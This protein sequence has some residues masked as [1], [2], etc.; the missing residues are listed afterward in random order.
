MNDLLTQ[1]LG[2]DEWATEF[3]E[4][5]LELARKIKEEILND[6][7]ISEEYKEKVRNGE[8]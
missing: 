5:A 8:K 7:W 4:H 3:P 6:K 1:L 2:L